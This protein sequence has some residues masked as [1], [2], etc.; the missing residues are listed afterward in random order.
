MPT[1]G[2]LNFDLQPEPGKSF[3]PYNNMRANEA[4]AKIK[5]REAI[6]H[7]E[8]TRKKVEL[9]LV[10]ASHGSHLEGLEPRLLTDHDLLLF[11]KFEKRTLTVTELKR[12]LHFLRQSGVS[13]R[14][15]SSVKLLDYLYLKMR[16]KKVKPQDKQ[17]N[18]N[19]H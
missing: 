3:T 19:F 12:Q 4:E 2:M 17:N 6:Q 10:S 8:N 5:S 7:Q 13:K 16:A 15:A 11:D 1:E 14:T 18:L 9:L